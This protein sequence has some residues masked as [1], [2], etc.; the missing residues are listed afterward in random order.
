MAC[1]RDQ[2]TN[3]YRDSFFFVCVVEE[4]DSIVVVAAVV[5]VI[6]FFITISVFV[7]SDSRMPAAFTLLSCAAAAASGV[8]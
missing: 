5:V 1:R 6:F 3:E 7:F 2:K 8:G 4:R